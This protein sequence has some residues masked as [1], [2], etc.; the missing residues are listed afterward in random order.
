MINQCP[1]LKNIDQ[2]MKILLKQLIKG[3]LKTR[4]RKR[5]TPLFDNYFPA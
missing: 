3:G 5:A 2:N 1:D 4:R